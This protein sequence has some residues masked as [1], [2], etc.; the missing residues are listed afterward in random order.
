M[1][2]QG[3]STATFLRPLPEAIGAKRY[4]PDKWSVK[5]VIG[6]VIDAERVFSQRALFFARKSASPL[7][8]Y[9]QEEWTGV[10]GFERTLLKDLA[11]ELGLV[12]QSNLYLFRQLNDEAWVRR[13]I[14]SGYEVSVRALAFIIVG[15]ER[16]HL[17][18]LKTRY[19]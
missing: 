5:E 17:E 14:A 1:E 6:H 19:L 2:R 3:E 7:P 9:D 15:H 10:A 18:I 13:G 12:R 11:S 16:H 4:A 8:S